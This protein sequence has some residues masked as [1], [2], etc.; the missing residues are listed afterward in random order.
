VFASA[1]VHLLRGGLQPLGGGGGGGGRRRA[2]AAEDSEDGAS[3]QAAVGDGEVGFVQ[4]ALSLS[5]TES[6]DAA[7]ACV[8]IQHERHSIDVMSALLKKVGSPFS[9]EELTLAHLLLYLIFVCVFYSVIQIK[10]NTILSYIMYKRER[11]K[12]YR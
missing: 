6:S 7:I 2:P 12:R 3:H 11:L 9:H 8:V 4:S 10:Y 5:V 1:S